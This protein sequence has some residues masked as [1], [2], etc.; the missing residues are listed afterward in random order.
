M[1]Q[2][3]NGKS[4]AYTPAFTGAAAAEAALASTFEGSALGAGGL[5][6]GGAAL[7]GAD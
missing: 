3:K 7:E 5:E 6:T 1:S 2:H 4:Q